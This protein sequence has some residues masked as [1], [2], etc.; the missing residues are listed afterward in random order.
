M[1]L[2]SSG[3]ANARY[4][5]VSTTTALIK[6]CAPVSTLHVSTVPS[7]L[8]SCWNILVCTVTNDVIC[9]P[10]HVPGLMPFYVMTL[11]SKPDMII[12]A[13]VPPGGLECLP[14]GGIS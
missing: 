10:T 1:L 3:P 4:L 12:S 8:R 11:H 7:Q 14:A 5:P 6:L 2:A 13:D 9:F